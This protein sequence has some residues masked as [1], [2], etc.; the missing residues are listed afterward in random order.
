MA[1]KAPIPMNIKTSAITAVL[2]TACVAPVI[3]KTTL[4]IFSFPGL[5]EIIPIKI[6]VNTAIDQDMRKR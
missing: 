2:G 3:D 4:P 6:P 5:V 1:G